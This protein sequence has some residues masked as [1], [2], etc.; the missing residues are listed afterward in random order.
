[1]K[2]LNVRIVFFFLTSAQPLDPVF[3]L[4]C[5][6][7]NVICSV[8]FNERFHYNNKT[9][10]SLLSL[11]NKNFNRINSPWNQVKPSLHL[12]LRLISWGHWDPIGRV[13]GC[14]LPPCPM[15]MC[16]QALSPS[17]HVCLVEWMSAV[18]LT[19]APME[20]CPLL[21]SVS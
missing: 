20:G 12:P 1:M 13:K 8:L 3:T 6:S 18:S 10:L 17:L 2:I 11:L 21:A 5:A 15:S 4:S 7:C 14:E 16:Q 9:L 19:P